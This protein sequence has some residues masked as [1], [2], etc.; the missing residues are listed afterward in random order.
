MVRTAAVLLILTLAVGICPAAPIPL[1]NPSFEV[2][3]NND[4]MPDNWEDIHGLDPADP[5]DGPAYTLSQQ[6]TNVEMYLNSLVAS[7]MEAG[8]EGAES[9]LR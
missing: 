7:I 5:L 3:E 8:L 4:G 9:N 1:V 2:D 6:Y